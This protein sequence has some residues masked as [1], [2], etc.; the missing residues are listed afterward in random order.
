LIGFTI[1]NQAAVGQP[2]A[3]SLGLLAT[4]GVEATAGL[5]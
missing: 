3:N 5:R 4:A 1:R 2:G